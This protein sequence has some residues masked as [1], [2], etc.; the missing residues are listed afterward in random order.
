MPDIR[1]PSLTSVL[2]EMFDTHVA[3]AEFAIEVLGGGTV[4]DVRR[5]S[6]RAFIE[7]GV[8]P[9]SLV[10]KTQLK[11]DRH[12]DP[13]CW[14]R[15]YAIYKDGLDRRLFPSIKMPRRYLLDEAEES[16][17]IW[18]EYVEGATGST[19]LHASELALAA[20]KLGELQAEF[21]LN[22]QRDLPYLRRCPAVRSSFGTA[23]WAKTPWMR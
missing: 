14:R 19:E 9:F 16:T 22:G 1:K 20:E 7:G 15:E 17:H 5:I 10:L 18:M 8:R 23:E 12:G 4:G 21:H 13:D 6:G 3:D 11:W 2:G